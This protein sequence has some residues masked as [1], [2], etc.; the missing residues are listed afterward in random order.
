M[1]HLP[2]KIRLSVVVAVFLYGT[3]RYAVDDPCTL[4]GELMGF[5]RDHSTHRHAL[6]RRSALNSPV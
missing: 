4:M 5:I 3:H 1:G 6:T 2:E